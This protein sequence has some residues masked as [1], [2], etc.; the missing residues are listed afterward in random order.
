M[1]PGRVGP[2]HIGAV[3]VANARSQKRAVRLL[4]WSRQG[5]RFHITLSESRRNLNNM[6]GASE[7]N[8]ALIFRRRSAHKR[9][10]GERRGLDRLFGDFGHSREAFLIRTISRATSAI[11]NCRCSPDSP[12]V[13]DTASTSTRLHFPADLVP[14]STPRLEM[15]RS[16]FASA[17][18]RRA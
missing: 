6:Q 15:E 18:L 13:G 7:H 5:R 14:R 16:F 2:G 10:A 12:N 3:F 4:G 1:T 11:T 9:P 8:R 17:R